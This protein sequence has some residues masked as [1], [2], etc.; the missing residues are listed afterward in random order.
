MPHA[1]THITGLLQ[2]G[3]GK[4]RKTCCR[5]WHMGNTQG[6][7]CN[8]QRG[9]ISPDL[10]TSLCYAWFD[11]ECRSEKHTISLIEQWK[12]TQYSNTSLICTQDAM[13]HAEA[14]FVEMD[15]RSNKRQRVSN[16]P[17]SICKAIDCPY[18]W[19]ADALSFCGFW[20]TSH[21]WY[22]YITIHVNCVKT[23]R[24]L[25]RFASLVSRSIILIFLLP[26][27]D[28][29]SYNCTNVQ[30]PEQRSLGGFPYERRRT[31]ICLPKSNGCSLPQLTTQPVHT[32]KCWRS[33]QTSQNLHCARFCSE[34]E[35]INE[36]KCVSF[37]WSKL[38]V[39]STMSYV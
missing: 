15:V 26:C 10:L 11:A 32:W 25:S 7:S 17:I 16:M 37:C 21:I 5:G 8:R 39:F 35:W 23:C 24:S 34:S 6:S 38:N 22:L 19:G 36:S 4:K 33:C 13:V 28:E 9:N 20:I 18:S 1:H 30:F 3:F 27:N 2:I 29:S 12:T 14:R 31:K